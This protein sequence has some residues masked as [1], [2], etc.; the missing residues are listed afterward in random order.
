MA[1]VLAIGGNLPEWTDEERAEAAG[2]VALYKRIAPVVQHGDLHRLLPPD[3]DRLVA[4]QYVAAGGDESVLFC[5]LPAPHF[6][7]AVAP[8]RLRGLDPAAL[9]RDEETG[10]VHHG[11]V[12]LGYGLHPRLPAGDYA[13][14]VVHLLRV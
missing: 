13:S 5:W 11:A 8:V 9:Y 3:G 6:G 2:W 10:E 7:R 1:G 14:T 12:L 4:T